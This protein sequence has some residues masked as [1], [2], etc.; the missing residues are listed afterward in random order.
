M[1]VVLCSFLRSAELLPI[2]GNAAPEDIS[3]I[4]TYANNAVDSMN[5]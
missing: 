5:K 2:A 4:I 3:R 1:T